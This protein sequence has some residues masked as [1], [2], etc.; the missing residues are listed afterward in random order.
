LL[1]QYSEHERTVL[2]LVDEEGQPLSAP[3]N[4]ESAD[5]DAEEDV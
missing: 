3:L 5:G 2:V 1:I 4:A